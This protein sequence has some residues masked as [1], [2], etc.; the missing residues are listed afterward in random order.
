MVMDN[1][2]DAGLRDPTRARFFGAELMWY[3]RPPRPAR[4]EL[5]S[6]VDHNNS[7]RTIPRLR[8]HVSQC[9]RASY[10]KT[11]AEAFLISNDPV[12]AV[13]LTKNKD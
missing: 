4:V 10:K 13:V 5:Q 1:S 3:G 11:A 2:G 7:P 12:A 8:A 9:F 6:F